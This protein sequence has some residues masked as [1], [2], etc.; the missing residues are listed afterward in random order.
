MESGV[1]DTMITLHYRNITGTEAAPAKILQGK[2][3]RLSALIKRNR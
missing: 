2:H 3:V 1:L